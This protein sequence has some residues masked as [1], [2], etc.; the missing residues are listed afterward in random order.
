MKLLNFINVL[1]TSASDGAVGDL[2]NTAYEEFLNVVNFVM[3]VLISVVLVFGIIYGI[4]LGINFAK[5]EDTESR[6]KAK[7]R[8][9]NL[10]IGVLVAVVIAGIIYAIL[11]NAGFIEDLFPKVTKNA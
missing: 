5:A 4:I 9:I 6:D 7:E 8:L 3:P 2:V 10:I 1:A 11:A